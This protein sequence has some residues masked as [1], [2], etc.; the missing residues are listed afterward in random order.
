M[1]LFLYRSWK[2]LSSSSV[3]G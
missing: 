2:V 1:I 3:Y